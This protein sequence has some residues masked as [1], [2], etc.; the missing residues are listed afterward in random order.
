MDR[1]VVLLHD[2]LAVVLAGGQGERL[3]PLTRDRSKPAVPFGGHYRIIDFT[4]SN[5]LNSGLRKIHVLTQYKS[6]SLERHIKRG[7]DPLF[8]PNLGEYLY[9]VPPQ[10]RVGQRWYQGTADAVYQNIYLLKSERPEL[11]LI[12]SG[13]HVYKMDY[14]RFVEYHESR[15]AV[16]TVGAVEVP[17]EQ[18]SAFGVLEVDEEWR[19][20]SFLEKP[21]NPKPIPGKPDRVLANM[22][23]YC[24]DT[25]TLLSAL[26]DDAGRESRHDFGHDILPTLAGGGQ[27]YAYPFLDEN[28]KPNLYWRDIGT[29]DSYYEAS[30]DLTS[31]DPQFNLYDSNWPILTLHRQLPPAKTVFAQIDKPDGRV[32]LALDSIVCGGVIISGGHV[33]RSILSPDV[34]VNSFAR[35]HSSVLMDGVDVGREARVKRAIVDKNVRIPP[36][37]VIGEDL[38]DDRRR[39]KVTEDGIVVIPRNT[40]LGG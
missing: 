13:D 10:L 15:R 20:T 36:G 31:V 37:Y 19:I 24:F 5:C 32:G 23:V 29:L 22:G 34:R 11:V 35:V 40:D 27:L 21:S 3:Y 14:S 18:A 30:M 16:A 28:R 1:R 7:W 2:V 17:I 33:E 39:F 12:L 4:L 25:Q 38:D 8:S 9:T 26:C 6:F